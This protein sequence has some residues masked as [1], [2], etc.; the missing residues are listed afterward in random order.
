MCGFCRC[1]GGA[2]S[3]EGVIILISRERPQGTVESPDCGVLRPDRSDKQRSVGGRIGK[4][5][6]PVIWTVNHTLL[7]MYLLLALAVSFLCSLLEAA[8]LSVPQTH[9]AVMV[10]RGSRSGALLQ[11]MKDNIDR[12]LAAI[13]T[14]NTFAHTIG[15]AGVGAQA[16][17]LFGEASV[18]IVSAV[19]TLLILIGS[20]IIPKSLG[21]MHGRSLAGFTAQTVRLLIFMLYPLV[22]VCELLSRWL[23]RN[24]PNI[25]VSRDEVRTLAK[26]GH[27]FGSI[28]EDEARVIANLMALNKIG[29]GQVMTPRTVCV[30]LQQDMNIDEALERCVQTP[31]SR[32]PVY[33]ENPDDMKGLVLR[34]MMADR[35]REQRGHEPLKSIL[36]PIQV[37]PEAAS[38]DNIMWKFLSTGQHMFL[39]VDEYGGTAGV[40]TF[41]DAIETMIGHEIVD[42]TDR[43][44]DM[45]HLARK[46]AALRER[47][48]IRGQRGMP[49]DRNGS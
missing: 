35:A 46:Q 15:A 37:V 5:S 16:T 18:G 4:R 3:A 17:I 12:P 28:E 38:V 31:H 43:V 49:G 23:S 33:G 29:V 41:E 7:I 34:R 2:E 39:V 44:V 30:M 47:R 8:L 10:D 20:E 36:R 19:V 48:R 25:G 26:L 13:L 42:E 9:V 27:Q 24:A 6:A 14:L 45:Q 40:V 22:V 32:F 11:R 1:I 21:A